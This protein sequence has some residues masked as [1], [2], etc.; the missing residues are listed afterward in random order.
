MLF[1]ILTDVHESKYQ[2]VT[3]SKEGKIAVWA[4][5]RVEKNCERLL[6]SIDL[7]K[8]CRK[9]CL[10]GEQLFCLCDGDILQVNLKSRG[11]QLIASIKEKEISKVDARTIENND[12]VLAVHMDQKILFFKDDKITREIHVSGQRLFSNDGSLLANVKTSG[13]LELFKSGS[14][15]LPQGSANSR[16]LVSVVKKK[17]VPLPHPPVKR[18]VESH[19][20][21][22]K[23]SIDLFMATSK[24]NLLELLKSGPLEYPSQ[25]RP[26]VW[27]SLSSLPRDKKMYL[28]FCK[29]FNSKPEDIMENIYL[30]SP[31][32]KLVSYL[33]ALL[34]PFMKV[35]SGHPTTTFEFCI[36]FLLHFSW[37]SSYPDLP[38]IVPFAWNL[39]E[40]ELP[41]LT[42]HLNNISVTPRAL[43]LPI[44]QS[45]WQNILKESEMLKLWDHIMTSG[46]EYLIVTLPATAMALQSNLLKCSSS[47][48]VLDLLSNLQ[49]LDIGYLLSKAYYLVS[50]YE[51]DLKSSSAFSLKFSVIS[52]AYPPA[53]VLSK[54]NHAV[55]ESIHAEEIPTG[56]SDDKQSRSSLSKNDIVQAA[57]AISPP[58]VPRLRTNQRMN[59]LEEHNNLKSG[60]DPSSV[61]LAS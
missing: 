46:V 15:W 18:N 5:P 35:F 7:E 37:V 22:K 39:L 48:M 34:T 32:L 20:E 45:A 12:I 16:P 29:R 10:Q 8:E 27:A 23:E 19:K 26:T 25:S 40:L 42:S 21:G 9:V 56:P 59:I 13:S 50:K 58:P 55:L 54:D 1:K 51:W 2:V 60:L 24:D 36:T 43:F 49:K 3:L 33:P 52:D 14:Y 57:L 30:W 31:H 41:L 47:S 44:L 4:F 11:V 17:Q 38:D 6:Y 53:I 28:K 61:K